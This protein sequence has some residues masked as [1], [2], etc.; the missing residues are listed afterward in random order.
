MHHGRCSSWSVEILKTLILRQFHRAWRSFRKNKCWEVWP[1]EQESRRTIRSVKQEASEEEGLGR[2]WP[3]R[4]GVRRGRVVEARHL[5]TSCY[6]WRAT[7]RSRRQG[8][9]SRKERAKGK[10]ERASAPVEFV[11]ASWELIR[12]RDAGKRG[13]SP[14]LPLPLPLQRLWW[15]RNKCLFFLFSCLSFPFRLLNCSLGGLTG[16]HARS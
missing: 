16:I 8:R 5:L 10:K 14:P 12:R 3:Q 4:R 9:D 11:W 7:R 15:G 13:R 6:F 2:S 1:P